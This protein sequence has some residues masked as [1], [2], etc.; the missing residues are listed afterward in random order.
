MRDGIDIKSEKKSMVIAHQGSSYG[1]AR[2]VEYVLFF[3][4]SYV[5]HMKQ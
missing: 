4:P 5:Q 3:L 2:N 1:D